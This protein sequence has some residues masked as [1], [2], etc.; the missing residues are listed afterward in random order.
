M[1]ASSRLCWVKLFWTE[2][3]D[4]DAPDID[5]KGYLESAVYHNADPDPD[6]DPDPDADPALQNCDRM[7]W[8]EGAPEQQSY[9][10]KM[11]M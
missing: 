7:G 2:L 9:F 1:Y 10:E 8:S 6:E 11:M 3:C 5:F 4:R